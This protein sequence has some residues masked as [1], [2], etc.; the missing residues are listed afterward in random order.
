MITLV[1]VGIYLYQRQVGNQWEMDGVTY[2]VGH[3]KRVAW[4]SFVSQYKGDACTVYLLPHHHMLHI[5]APTY[6]CT[7]ISASTY[8]HPHHVLY[9]L[10]TCAEQ[11]VSLIVY[12]TIEF[13]LPQYKSDA[14]TVHICTHT[15][16]TTKPVHTCVILATV[17]RI[18][19]I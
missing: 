5:S 13:G 2:Y 9:V 8:L 12:D 18:L 3:S 14:C 6:T 1:H 15:T 19:L 11:M 17:L 7:H 4:S 10:H 16:T